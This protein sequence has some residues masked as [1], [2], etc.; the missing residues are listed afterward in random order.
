MGCRTRLNSNWT[1]DPST[2][3]LRTGNLAYISLNL[4]R[5]ALKGNFWEQLDHAMEVAA[6]VLLIRKEHGIKLM[7]KKNESII[8]KNNKSI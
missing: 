6:E 1:G 4:P 5:Y 8:S 7:E 2:D 3:C